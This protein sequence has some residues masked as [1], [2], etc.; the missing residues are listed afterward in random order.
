[1]SVLVIR[2]D[3]S[4]NSISMSEEIWNRMERFNEK[5]EGNRPFFHQIMGKR[6]NYAHPFWQLPLSIPSGAGTVGQ[7]DTLQLFSLPSNLMRFVYTL[8]YE[9]LVWH[10]TKK[11][12]K[13]FLR[14]S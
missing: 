2:K 8:S 3:N 14:I 1:M 10:S 12:V 13:Q 4:S 11:V 9:S 7:L 6:T 5:T